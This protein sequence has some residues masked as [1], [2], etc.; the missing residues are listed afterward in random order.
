MLEWN[1]NVD[2]WQDMCIGIVVENGVV[3]GVIIFMGIIVWLKVVVL[4]N[5]IFLNGLIYF[6]EKQFGGGCVVEWVVIGIIECLLE[7]GFEV[8]WMKIGMLF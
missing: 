5:G 1:L 7:L 6:G 4:M 2:F 3:V 8:G